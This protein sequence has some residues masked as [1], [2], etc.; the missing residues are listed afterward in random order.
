[1][2]KLN[3]R[4]HTT[5]SMHSLL[6]DMA[7]D[8]YEQPQPIT[9]EQVHKLWEDMVKRLDKDKLKVACVNYKQICKQLSLTINQS[10]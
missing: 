4:H 6:S 8:A 3:N 1:M 2:P 9:E 7:K 5:K 10:A